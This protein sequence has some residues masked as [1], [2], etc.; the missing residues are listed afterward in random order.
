MHRD[1]ARIMRL[2]LDTNVWL[3][4]L[5]FRDPRSIHVL[6]ALQRGR[7]HALVRPDGRE[8]WMRVLGYRAL[9]LDPATGQRLLDAFDTLALMLPAAVSA[10][11]VSPPSSPSPVALP[12]CAD[13]DDQK[14][15]QLARDAAA[16]VLL[17][18]DR[19]LLRLSARMR[20]AG[21]CPILQPVEWRLPA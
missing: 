11:D 13:P 7:A 17:T 5:W 14:F 10:S 18:R 16:D 9:A 8:E 12:R 15:L 3:D 4:L 20:R 21:L 1:G 6:E 19:E 2:I